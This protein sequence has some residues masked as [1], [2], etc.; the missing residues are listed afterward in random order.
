MVRVT[1]IFLAVLALYGTPVWLFQQLVMPQLAAL[2]SVYNNAEA[3]AQQLSG[4]ADAGGVW[5]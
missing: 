4:T 2:Q 3:T 5:Q 1:I